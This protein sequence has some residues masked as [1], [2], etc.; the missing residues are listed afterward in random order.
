MDISVKAVFFF[1]DLL[2]KFMWNLFINNKAASD[3]VFHYV[4]QVLQTGKK[5]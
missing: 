4:S 3:F 2:N 1:E 5:T